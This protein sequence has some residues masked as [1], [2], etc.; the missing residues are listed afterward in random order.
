[1]RLSLHFTTAAVILA[2]MY[3]SARADTTINTVPPVFTSASSFGISS[4]QTF[5][6]TITAPTNGDDYLRSFTFILQ[7]TSMQFQLEVYA[8][9]GTRATGPNLYESAPTSVPGA[10]AEQPVTFNFNPGVGL[11]AGGEYIAF[12]STSK[13]NVPGNSGSDVIYLSGFNYQPYTG[14]KAVYLNN[15]ADFTQWTTQPWSTI[16]GDIHGPEDIDFAA[17]FSASVPEPGLC[18]PVL[19]LL[20]GVVLQRP[21]RLSGSL[22]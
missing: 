21:R 15:G 22:R 8:W 12:L 3:V 7:P 4:V 18:W 5:G 9:N 20:G 19:G 10:G 16:G 11:S 1:M 13:M 17:S 14:G 2:A 6:Q